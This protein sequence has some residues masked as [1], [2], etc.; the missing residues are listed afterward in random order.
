MVQQDRTGTRRHDR[1]RVTDRIQVSWPNRAGGENFAT[2]EAFD[3]CESGMSFILNEA[4]PQ[5]SYVTLRSLKLAVQGRAIVRHC[6]R[7]GVKN[8]IGVEFSGGFLWKHKPAG[9]DSF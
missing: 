1:E 5:Q 2:V 9:S 8:L 4:L 7:N 6:V 3:I